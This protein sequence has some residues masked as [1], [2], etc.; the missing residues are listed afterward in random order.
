MMETPQ[1]SDDDISNHNVPQCDDDDDDE[2][3]QSGDLCLI[4]VNKHTK[5]FALIDIDKLEKKLVE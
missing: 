5:D 3:L 2:V 1:S 4:V